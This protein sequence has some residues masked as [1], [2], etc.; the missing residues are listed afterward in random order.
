MTQ[1]N[2]E[3]KKGEKSKNTIMDFPN[4]Q[5]KNC[6]LAPMHWNKNQKGKEKEKGKDS[7][8]L[9]FLKILSFSFCFFL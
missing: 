8:I 1:D 9:V 2:E 3:K 4:P 7:P 6:A 5:L